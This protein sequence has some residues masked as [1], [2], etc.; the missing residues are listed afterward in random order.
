MDYNHFYVISKH[1]EIRK[2]KIKDFIRNKTLAQIY[3][4]FQYENR[5]SSM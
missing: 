4:K 3:T 2:I 5:S 1:N